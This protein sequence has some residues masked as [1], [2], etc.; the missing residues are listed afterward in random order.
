[1]IWNE[2]LCLGDSLTYGARDRY[3][4]SYPAELGSILTEKTKDFYICH[5]YGVNGETSSDLLRRSWQILKSN[6]G[7]KICLL[8]IGTNDTKNPTPLSIYEDNLK[9]IINSIRA[10]GMIPIVGTLPELTFSPF[11]ARN[12]DFT[13][14][15]NK[16]ITKLSESMNFDLCLMEDMEEYLIDG[17]HFCHEGYNEIAKRWSESILSLK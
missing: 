14:K 5:N 17:V 15:Y 8:L 6:K 1:M 7:A 2:I 9:Q 16:S 13:K 4:R 12:R 10:N 3:G 11:Y